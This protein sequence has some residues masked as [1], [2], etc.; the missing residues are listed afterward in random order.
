MLHRERGASE[1]AS[2]EPLAADLIAIAGGCSARDARG[3][4]GKLSLRGY[5]VEARASDAIERSRP[6]AFDERA[7]GV[8][9][10]ALDSWNQ[11]ASSALRT[12][13]GAAG[14]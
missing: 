2:D 4:S 6:T 7:K 13:A 9:A 3:L 11:R 14:R 1:M 10:N 5:F 8:C 12:A